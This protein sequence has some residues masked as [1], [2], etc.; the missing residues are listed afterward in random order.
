M[1]LGPPPVTEDIKVLK[2]WC[3]DL[4]DFLKH[5]VFQVIEIGDI[6]GGNYVTFSNTGDAVFVGSSGLSFGSCYGN[7]IAWTQASAVQN[8]WYNI[9]DE[10]MTDGVLN[11]IAHD[12]SG[13]LTVTY[14]GMYLVNYMLCYEND[15]AN[16]H[17]EVGIEISASGS[18]NAAGMSHSEN[19][20]A[21][22]EEHLSGTAILDLAAG[23]TIEIAIRTLD[24]A[25][26]DFTVHSLNITVV[27]LGGT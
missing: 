22:E 13:K 10:D 19:K 12:G 7:H 5:P 27:Q 11:N 25:T 3:D 6:L 9:A 23:A 21:S 14:A 16:D 20:F 24:A 1:N 8:T 17:V 26:P 4:Y 15:T 2:S 18:A